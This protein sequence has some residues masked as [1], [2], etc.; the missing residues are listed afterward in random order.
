M[1]EADQEKVITVEEEQITIHDPEKYLQEAQEKFSR[2]GRVS[3][4]VERALGKRQVGR[5]GWWPQEKK[6]EVAT[7]F[8]AGMESPL[9]L[10]RITRVPA[11]TIR[12]WRREEWFH[13]LL[14]DINVEHD[15]KIVGKLGN[16]VDKALDQIQDRINS[17]DYQYN[18]KTGEVTRVPAKLRDLTTATSTIV[19][20][21]QLLR[22]KATSRTEKVDADG[23]LAKLAAEFRKFVGAKDITKEV[24]ILP[25]NGE[26]QDHEGTT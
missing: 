26:G 7:L 3:S 25:N 17:G 13:E 23:R 11:P 10:E 2:G 12:D 4:D 14:E 21:R 15:K 16:I 20:K 8:A 19:D 18:R 1:A 5:R 6:V 9:E 24:E 22:G